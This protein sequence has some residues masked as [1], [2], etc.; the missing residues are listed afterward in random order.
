VRTAARLALPHRRRRTPF[1]APGLDDQQLEDALD[2]VPPAA[3]APEGGP[4]DGPDGGPEDDGPSGGGAPEPSS[5]DGPPED[6][7]EGEAQERDAA[8]AGALAGT[9]QSPA[10]AGPT[11]APVALSVPGVN[12]RA[13]PPGG[14]RA[15][16]AAAA[17]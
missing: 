9:E 16:R 3:G 5:S 10:A 13:G 15:P 12:R 11:F 4:E 17:A 6:P 1:E 7:A 2:S 14:G 8:P